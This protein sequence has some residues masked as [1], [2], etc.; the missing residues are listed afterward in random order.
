MEIKES[1]MEKIGNK[2]KRNCS[3]P[4]NLGQRKSP[5]DILHCNLKYWFWSIRKGC[6]TIIKNLQPKY[7]S[8]KQCSTIAKAYRGVWKPGRGSKSPLWRRPEIRTKG[9][10]LLHSTWDSVNHP[11]ILHYNLKYWFW[12]IHKGC[13]TML[14]NLQPKYLLP[15]YVEP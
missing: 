9:I 7:L 13:L 5:L 15:N 2:G 12:S 6:L 14:K 3:P 1:F 10:V 4:L 8:S 11:Q